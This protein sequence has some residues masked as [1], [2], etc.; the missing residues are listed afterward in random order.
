MTLYFSL[1]ARPYSHRPCA[2]GRKEILE[3]YFFAEELF[4]SLISFKFYTRQRKSTQ[5]A[6]TQFPGSYSTLSPER[7]SLF[8]E[9]RRGPGERGCVYS[10]IEHKTAMQSWYKSGQ[11]IIQFSRKPLLGNDRT[12]ITASQ[13]QKRVVCVCVCVCVENINRQVSPLASNF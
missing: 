6:A 5:F 4:V 13:R 8:P 7:L 1:S 12:R 2:R 10:G 9:S 11:N 3:T